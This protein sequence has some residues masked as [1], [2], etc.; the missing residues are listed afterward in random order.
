MENITIKI[1]NNSDNAL[2]KYQTENSA[3]MDICANLGEGKSIS[4]QPMQRV[5]I[6][7]G[8]H[9]ELPEGYE[10]Q[11]RSRSGLSLKQGLAIIGGVGTIDSDYRGDVGVPIINFSD[12]PQIIHHGDRIAQAVIIK[13]ERVKFDVCENIAELSQTDRGEGGFGH[14]G[15]K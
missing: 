8:L 5:L 1:V 13:Y 11:I 10:M 4:I 12:T 6:L 9:V 2:P 7:S 3:G 15:V 14:T